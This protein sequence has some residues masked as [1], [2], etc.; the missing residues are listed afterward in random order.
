M[1]KAVEIVALIKGQGIKSKVDVDL[2][3]DFLHERAKALKGQPAEKLECL[4]AWAVNGVH[5]AANAI[6]GAVES[7]AMRV[8]DIMGKVRAGKPV[9]STRGAFSTRHSRVD[10]AAIRLEEADATLR[11]ILE[12]YESLAVDPPGAE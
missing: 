6:Q 9:E 3:D 7:D 8:N 11:R 10:T 4:L 2:V 12:V 5:S 1:K